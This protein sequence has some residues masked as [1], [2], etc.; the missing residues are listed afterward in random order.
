MCVTGANG[1]IASHVVA[2]LLEKGHTVHG[3]VRD[4]SDGAKTKHL[5]ELADATML[6]LFS[7]DLLGPCSKFVEAFQGCDGVIHIATPVKLGGMKEKGEK[8]IYEPATQGLRT[9]L[10]AMEKTEIKNF[11]LT[12]SM[13]AVAPKDE[14]SIKSEIH[15]SDP[16]LQ[17]EKKNWMG[18]AKTQV[19]LDAMDWAKNHQVRFVAICPTM[20][21]GPMLQPG[22]NA[23]MQFLADLVNGRIF[24]QCP[25]DS[26]SFIDVRDCAAHHV[27]AYEIDRHEGRFMS[28]VQ[29]IHWNDVIK[30]IKENLPEHRTMADITPFP[31]CDPVTPTQFDR[32]RM[33]SLGHHHQLRDIPTILQGALKALDDRGALILKTT[34]EVPDIKQTN[35]PFTIH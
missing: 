32:T 22:V 13:G 20:A 34:S 23:T 8:E 35:E 19:E 26:M 15:W 11:I 17:R 6:K 24:T 29:S 14:P 2:Q 21:L 12:S 7:A 28:V 9:I 3:T 25:N 27:I 31:G 16:A 1:F 18:A 33:D 30:I 5:R 10:E 4:A